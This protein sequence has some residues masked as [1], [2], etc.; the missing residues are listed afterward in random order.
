MSL[1]ASH[2]IPGSGMVPSMVGALL[3]ISSVH[4]SAP[5]PRQQL[6]FDTFNLLEWYGLMIM[7]LG[8]FSQTV[9]VHASLLPGA[10]SARMKTSK[11]PASSHDVMLKMPAREVLSMR[12]SSMHTDS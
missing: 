8:Y 1:A 10:G 11:Q 3:L 12:L 6:E 4:G 5:R 7:A 2:L 9:G